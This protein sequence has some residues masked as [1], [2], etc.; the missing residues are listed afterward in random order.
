MYNILHS[1]AGCYYANDTDLSNNE[2]RELFAR[3]NVE[4]HIRDRG[5]PTS[6]PEDELANRD[7]LPE[8]EIRW[9]LPL[10]AETVGDIVFPSPW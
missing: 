1:D 5:N 7:K 9:G 4:I 8:M 10:K 6:W 3:L 2:W